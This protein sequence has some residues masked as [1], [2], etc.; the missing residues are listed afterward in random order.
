MSYMK[1]YVFG[2]GL[3]MNGGSSRFCPHPR[4]EL[5]KYP[6]PPSEDIYKPAQAVL[7]SQTYKPVP[8]AVQVH[9]PQSY[10]GQG[11]KV[12][13]V[14]FVP[15]YVH[16]EKIIFRGHHELPVCVGMTNKHDRFAFTIHYNNNADTLYEPCHEINQRSAFR[17]G[18]TQTRLYSY[19]RWLEV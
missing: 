15:S 12:P 8:S 14:W 6:P 16:S 5:L 19:R 1:R 9:Q 4:H 13:T 2:L 10:S 11:N 7:R 17:P 3:Y 18:P